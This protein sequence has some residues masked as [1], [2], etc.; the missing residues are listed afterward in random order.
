MRNDCDISVEAI[1]DARLEALFR[2]HARPVAHDSER[3]VMDGAAFARLLSLL[4]GGADADD[5]SSE[6]SAESAGIPVT[7]DDDAEKQLPTFHNP[8]HSAGKQPVT[9]PRDDGSST[10]LHSSFASDSGTWLGWPM[11]NPR[12]VGRAT[13]GT[14]SASPVRAPARSVS[15]SPACQ[16]HAAPRC[17]SCCCG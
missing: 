11:L 7:P 8:L 13:A 9:L 17:S 4:E 5:R 1:S 6:A 16:P 10:A 14:M 3:H 15:A 12:S 2:E